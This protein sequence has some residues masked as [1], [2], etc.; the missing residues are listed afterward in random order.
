MRMLRIYYWRSNIQ[1][2]FDLHAGNI[3]SKAE[4]KHFGAVV[5]DSI[6]SCR[7]SSSNEYFAF[8]LKDCW[9]TLEIS[10]SSWGVDGVTYNR[11]DFFESVFLWRDPDLKNWWKSHSVC[12]DAHH[13]RKVFSC[14]VDYARYGSENTC[15]C[16][17]FAVK[18]K[19]FVFVC[20]NIDAWE[21]KFFM[22]FTNYVVKNYLDFFQLVI[23]N[24]DLRIIR[25][26]KDKIDISVKESY[27]RW[28]ASCWWSHD[29]VTYFPAVDT[30]NP[31]MYFL[32]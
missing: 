18:E 29:G 5:S 21:W 20:S 32:W 19:R 26:E 24:N 22:P 2:D 12:G 17:V 1:R 6:S 8:F 16:G 30:S 28:W 23:V 10:M 14:P 3:K 13:V 9:Y 7:I 31:A 4:T 25:K 27:T 15:I 11:T